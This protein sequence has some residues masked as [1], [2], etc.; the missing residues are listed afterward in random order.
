MTDNEN[1]PPPLPPVSEPTFS[2]IQGDKPE[3]PKD[4]APKRGRGRPRLDPKAEAAASTPYKPGVI[5]QGLTGLYGQLGMMLGMIDPHCGQAIIANAEVM[6]QSLE[7]LAKDNPAVREWLTRLVTTSVI[8]EV[9]AAHMPVAFAIF[10]HHTPIGRAKM[11]AATGLT[12]EN[13]QS[14]MNKEKPKP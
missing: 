7:K 1:T 10:M 2:V 8:G 3:T 4:S 6:A 5:S 13:L 9:I 12:D 11:E 14:M